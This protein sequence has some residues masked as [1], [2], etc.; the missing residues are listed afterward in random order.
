MSEFSFSARPHVN[1][2]FKTNGRVEIVVDSP[3]LA[4]GIFVQLQPAKKD[5]SEMIRHL[6]KRQLH[7]KITIKQAQKHFFKMASWSA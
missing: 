2:S 5:E 6:P 7:V 3:G 4:S 1:A